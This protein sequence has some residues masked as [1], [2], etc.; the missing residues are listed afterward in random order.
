MICPRC[1]RQNKK[2]SKF[3][4]ECGEV[5]LSIEPE[6]TLKDNKEMDSDDNNKLKTYSELAEDLANQGK[7]RREQCVACRG[8]GKKFSMKFLLS[9][10]LGIWVIP[11]I[12]LF[13][14][15]I[16]PSLIVSFIVLRWGWKSRTCGVCD[17]EGIVY[18]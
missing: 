15:T 17:G 4:S 5:L 18:L 7:R 12:G 16:I 10:F 6:S 2:R 13:F 11:W 9:I 1:G 3:C 8:K 14:G